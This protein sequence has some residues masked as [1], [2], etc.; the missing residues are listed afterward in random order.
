L[1]S[2]ITPARA[3]HD[4][5]VFEKDERVGGLL[6]Y[7]IPDFKLEKRII[8]RR[9]EQLRA[10]GVEFQTGVNVG[11]DISTRYLQ[12]M[13]DCVCLAMGASQPRDLNIPGRGYQ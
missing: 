10:E 12:K 13:F 8:D 5:V 1:H 3:G 4:V 2:T 11:E 6:R 9:L 7:G